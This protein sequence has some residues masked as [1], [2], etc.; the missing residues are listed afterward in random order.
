LLPGLVS[1]LALASASI[2]A[3]PAATVPATGSGAT[4]G[5]ATSGGAAPGATSPAP[6]PAPAPTSTTPAVT[7]DK[8]LGQRI[9][10]GFSGTSAPG[11]LVSAVRAGHVGSVILFASNI[12][13]RAQLQS[14]TGSLQAAARAGHNPPLLIAV[15]QEGGEVKRLQNG[16][17]TLSPPQMVHTGKV[18]VAS[19][20]GTATGRYLKGLGINWD[21]APVV[22]VPTFGGAFIW[23][24]GRAFSFNYKTVS[25]YATAFAL[26]L[27]GAKVAAAAKHFPGLGSAPVTT[28]AKLQELHPSATQRSQ[29]LVPYQTLIPKG[30]DSVLVSVAGFPAYDSSG[31]PAALSSKMIGGVLRRKLHFQGVAITDS[32]AAPTGHTEVA[33]GVLAAR[34]GADVLLYTDSAPGELGALEQALKKGQ[35]GQSA[36]ASSY[37]KILA[38]KRKVAG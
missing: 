1:T 36:A 21:L 38:L 34:A 19:Q 23:K 2:S 22:D 28:D 25:S 16:P 3:V 31:A 8:L 20:Q 14:L 33:A 6:T 15:D 27:Q 37:R 12:G 24:Q 7:P 26:G 9:M 32:L 18:S 13:T 29:A 30:L 17:P 11:W 35:I 5:G 10:V 4:S